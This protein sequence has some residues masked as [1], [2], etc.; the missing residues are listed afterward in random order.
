MRRL[1]AGLVLVLLTACGGDGGAAPDVSGGPPE[2]PPVDSKLLETD[3]TPAGAPFL[4]NA[5]KVQTA[6]RMNGGAEIT[7]MQFTPDG[8]FIA[9]IDY[10]DMNLRLWDWREGKVVS[11]QKHSR[12]PTS[13]A[14]DARGDGVWTVDAYANLHRWPIKKGQLGPGEL[15]GE[16]LGSNPHVAVSPNGRLIATS[17][18]ESTLSLWDAMGR[19]LLGKVQTPQ[20]LRACGFSP[21]GKK[22]VIGTTTNVLLEYDL[23]TGKGRYI[24]IPRV[25][26]DTELMTLAFSRDGKRFST[27][28]N[29]P[30]LTIWEASSMTY[31]HF[32]DCPMASLS[33][34][35]F[36][37]DGALVVFA[38]T[39]N[40]VHVW[41]TDDGRAVGDKLVLKEHTKPSRAVAFSPDG[42]LLATGDEAGSLIVW[43]KTE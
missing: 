24:Q 6:A 15:V 28:H 40:E 4:G 25:K 20:K 29:Q 21:N 38:M 37:G 10:S 13:M 19:K 17:S 22:L 12:R 36:S 39:N 42:T 41:E 2:L 32:K 34:V 11:R 7:A 16:D 31:L 9:S 14:L 35:E 43:T 23:A 26:P 3:A 5:A 33:D 18:W 1:I 30:Y 27:G 8:K